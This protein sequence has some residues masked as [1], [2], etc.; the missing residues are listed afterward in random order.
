MSA[1]PDEDIPVRCMGCGI[2]YS[3][4][5]RDFHDQRCRCAN[6]GEFKAQALAPR[7]PDP[8]PG[9]CGDQDDEDD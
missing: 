8:P 5:K 1:A 9:V 2:I 7:D 3:T 6:C 4:T